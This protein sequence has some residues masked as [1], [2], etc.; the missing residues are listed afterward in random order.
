MKPSSGQKIKEPEEP[1]R[2]YLMLEA[3]GLKK[4]RKSPINDK[5]SKTPLRGY[6]ETQER[7]GPQDFDIIQSDSFKTHIDNLRSNAENILKRFIPKENFRLILTNR[8]M[9]RMR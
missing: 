1:K 9:W 6:N 4:T 5:V 7:I 8:S 2:I 3:S